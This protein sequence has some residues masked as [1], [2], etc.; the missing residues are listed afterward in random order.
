MPSEAISPQTTRRAF[1]G[2]W[3]L[4]AALTLRVASVL[5]A[6]QVLY[7]QDGKG[8]S[9]VQDVHLGVPQ[10]LKHGRL[11]GVDGDHPCALQA[12]REFNPIFVSI[13]NRQGKDAAPEAIGDGKARDRAGQFSADFESP[14]FV[15]QAFVVLETATADHKKYLFVHEIDPLVPYQTSHVTLTIPVAAPLDAGRCV[16]HVFSHGREV[17]TSAMTPNERETIL[18]QMVADRI[19]GV[20]SQAAQPMIG[21]TPEYPKSLGRTG[22]TGTATVAF[23]IGR[24]G[25]VQDA[26]V[27]LA[28]RPEFGESALAAIHL[29]RF[30]PPVAYGVAGT[31]PA[32]MPFVFEAPA[33]K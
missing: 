31:T 19:H 24:N 20:V 25:A 2:R 23:R 11:E 1:P 3:L 15:D 6:Q 10:V 9:W 32:E 30:L 26:R 21:P 13:T 27:K 17:M 18:D 33:E 7:V 22:A 4:F 8:F 16:L 28:S 29:W 12:V 14:Y 5:S